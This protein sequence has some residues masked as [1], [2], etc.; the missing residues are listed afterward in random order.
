MTRAINMHGRWPLQVLAA[1]LLWLPLLA[2]ATALSDISAT[3]SRREFLM[4]RSLV[5][6][7]LVSDSFDPALIG[8]FRIC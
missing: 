5:R 1:L 8:R 6:C 3:H 7:V 4:T 2:W